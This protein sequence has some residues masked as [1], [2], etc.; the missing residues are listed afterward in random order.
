MQQRQLQEAA[1]AG[2]YAHSPAAH[3][4]N[5]PSAQPRVARAAEPPKRNSVFD[6]LDE[7]PNS[8]PKARAAAEVPAYDARQG[9]RSTVQVLSVCLYLTL[10]A[11]PDVLLP[12]GCYTSISCLLTFNI[13]SP[14]SSV[15]VGGADSD[16]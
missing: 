6:R 15:A 16:W 2:S 9:P 1:R 5:A 3:R 10:S 11:C 14:V 8:Q 4:G 7:E 13:P 12:Y